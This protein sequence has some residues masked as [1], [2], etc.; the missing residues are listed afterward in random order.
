MRQACGHAFDVPLDAEPEV[1]IGIV[2]RAQPE[3][4]SLVVP[5]PCEQIRVG[6]D[7]L[8]L[9]CDTGVIEGWPL[10]RCDG[11]EWKYGSHDAFSVSHS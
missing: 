7:P 8:P 11:D 9:A 4:V 10:D 1:E 5:V 2:V 3:N 6:V